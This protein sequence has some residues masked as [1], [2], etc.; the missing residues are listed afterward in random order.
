MQWP[1]A[2]VTVVHLFTFD[3]SICFIISLLIELFL[4]LFM[5]LADY[6][7]RTYWRSFLDELL[8]GSYTC[9]RTVH[10]CCTVLTNRNT[11][12]G[13]TFSLHMPTALLACI[14]TALNA[15][16]KPNF[17]VMQLMHWFSDTRTAPKQSKHPFNVWIVSW[18][19]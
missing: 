14:S 15:L 10:S 4:S 2:T 6:Y 8:D 13:T 17:L 11:R 3:T 19:C 1:P 5:I 16:Q 7:C 18:V 12:S 9:C